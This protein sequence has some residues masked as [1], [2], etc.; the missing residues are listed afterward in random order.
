MQTTHGIKIHLMGRKIDFQNK[1]TKMQNHRTK[2][3]RNTMRFTQRS[4]ND[5]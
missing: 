5:M 3:E 4:C 2:D 1:R